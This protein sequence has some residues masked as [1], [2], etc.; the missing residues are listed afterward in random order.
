MHDIKFI[1]KNHD[2]FTKKI[3][4]RN[5]KIDILK[6]L[7]LDK[8][9]RDLILTKEKL[10]QEKGIISQKK[11]K[12]Q[13]KRSKEISKELDKINTDQIKIK[14]ELDVLISLIPN[15]A[16]DDVNEECPDTRSR[17]RSGKAEGGVI[18]FDG[19]DD[20]SLDRQV[21]KKGKYQY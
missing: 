1:R 5:L 2:F 13:F 8:K 15:I 7:K 16:L 17:Y 21:Q 4:E 11:D 20:Y 10:E 3:E 18:F 6:I 9:N 14:K 19:T 12:S